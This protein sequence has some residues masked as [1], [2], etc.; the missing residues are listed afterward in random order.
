MKPYPLRL[1][2]CAA[3]AFMAACASGSSSGA[4]AA[5]TRVSPPEILVRGGAPSLR[6]PTTQSGRSPVRIT[7]EVV[8]DTTGRPDMST[9]KITGY[10]AAE[11][12][13]ALADW[14][15]GS[16]FRPARQGDQPVPGVYRT[17]LEARVVTVTH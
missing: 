4:G 9:L 6:V 15:E 10:G 5:P 8:I 3:F 16:I 11:N 14:I 7:I 17:Q 12:H 1:T 2:L 13:Y